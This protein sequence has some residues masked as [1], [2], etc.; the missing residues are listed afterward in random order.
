MNKARVVLEGL[1]SGVPYRETAEA[2]T[3]G[4]ERLLGELEEQLEAIE[5]GRRPRVWGRVLRAHYGEGKTHLLHA[6]AALA[7]DRNW[8]V[9]LL[10]V[11]KET[12]LDRPDYF[13][14]KL[15]AATYRPG[16][17]QPGIE[18]LVLEAKA[19]PHFFIQLPEEQLSERVR[20][21]VKCLAHPEADQGL[22]MADLS[23]EFAPLTTLRQMYRGLFRGA[24]RTE[25]ASTRLKMRE[26][27]WSYLRFVDWLVGFTGHRGWLLLFD[28]VELIGKYSR[29]QRAWSYANLGRFLEGIGERTYTV[30]AVAGNFETD[31]LE[32]R[33]D[34]ELAPRWLEVRAPE[35]LAHAR[36]ALNELVTARALEPLREGEIRALLSRLV[37]LH[38]SAYEWKAPVSGDQ[39]YEEVKARVEVWDLRLR[40]WVRL[41][42]W[43]L[44]MWQQYGEEVAV[45][46]T[47]ISDQDLS[48]EPAMA[49]EESSEDSPPPSRW[50]PLTGL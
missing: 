3:V 27:A 47:P 23:G 6:L 24:R 34:R 8:V 15:I 46:V 20:M 12:P 2:V 41:A 1:R 28:E 48:E 18:P 30:W 33:N 11:S 5:R 36:L 35:E 37:A 7:H 43:L 14:G 4:R 9:S 21:V 32:P 31:V 19:S 39:L 25:P 38:E 49:S 45:K 26:E 17:H 13:Y 44:D 42:L 16:S 29:G 50:R 40:T 22:L 10:P